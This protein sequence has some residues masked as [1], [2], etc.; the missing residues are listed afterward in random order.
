VNFVPVRIA[1]FDPIRDISI[2]EPV[3]DAINFGF[4]YSLSGS[5]QAPPGTSVTNLSFPHTD[6]GRLVLTQHVSS[7]GARIFLG[8]SGSRVKH[9]V[10]IPRL[11]QVSL[12]G[13]FFS[14][15]ANLF[16]L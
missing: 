1:A 9:L 6:S 4:G 15:T 16:A 3:D 10:L 5:D 12:E 13:Q 8:S 7:V 11:D 14:I 2:L